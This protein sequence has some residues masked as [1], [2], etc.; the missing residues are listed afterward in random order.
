MCPSNEGGWVGAGTTLKNYPLTKQDAWVVKMDEFGNTCPIANCDTAI[1]VRA[2]WP[3]AETSQ[4]TVFPNPNQGEFQVSIIST[5]FNQA[6]IGL[7]DI[8]GHE[9]W[10]ESFAHFPG[11]RMLHFSDL[12]AGVYLLQLVSEKGGQFVRVVIQN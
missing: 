1:T 7:F 11:Y 2:I 4:L 10:R 5:G 9:I 3:E 12:A 6:T 8:S